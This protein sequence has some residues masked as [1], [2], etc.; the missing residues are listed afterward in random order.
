[1]QGKFIVVEGLEGAGKS[2]A[3][4][5]IK[6]WLSARGLTK[7]INT[8][9]PGGTPIAEDIRAITKQVYANDQ[10]DE[11]TELLLMYAA[12]VQLVNT[13]IRPAL[14]D[15][16]WVI[17]DRHEMSTLAYQ[18][19]GRGIDQIKL[20]NLSSL[21][22]TGFKPDLTIYLDIDPKL[23]LE[24]VANRGAKDRFEQESIDFFTKIRK[25]YQKLTLDNDQ[26]FMI[27]AS[28]NIVDVQAEIAKVLMA[29]SGLN[30]GK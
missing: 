22:L 5:Y 14:A 27:D 24:R 18:G 16:Y 15:G 9:E 8:R 12:R 11:I 20:A 13:I 17:G 7:L 1:M 4:A 19:G 29:N 3:I 25:V 21:V 6:Q 30:Y 23:G 2:S 28:Q 26:A 10:M